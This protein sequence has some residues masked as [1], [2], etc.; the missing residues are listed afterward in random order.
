MRTDSRPTGGR[1]RPS[2]RTETAIV[3]GVGLALTLLAALLA[4]APPNLIR[5]LDHRVYDTLLN[6]T[7]SQA[8]S[9]IPVLI[10]IDDASLQRYGQWPWPRYRLA[11]LIARLDQAGARVIAL[12]LLMPES[13]RTSPEIILQERHRDLGDLSP[14]GVFRNGPPGNDLLLA[15]TL[16]E[17]PVV[18]GYRFDFSSTGKGWAGQEP[19]PLKAMVVHQVAGAASG[20]PKP[21]GVLANLP[22]LAKAAP[23]EGF[24]NAGTDGDGILR[25]VPVLIEGPHGIFP[26][27]AFAALLQATGEEAVKL[28]IRRGAA[29]LHWNGREIPLDGQ[30]NLLLAFRG[31][32]KSYRY[33]SSADVLAGNLPAGTLQGRVA[34][35]GAWASGLGDRHV[36]PTDS[37]FPGM[38]VHAVVIDNLLA[39]VF[40][41]EPPWSR[42][43]QLFF[44]VCLGLLTTFVLSRFDFLADLLLLGTGSLLTAGGAC[45]LFMTQGIYLSP[46]IPVLLLFTSCGLLGLVKY[47]L[48]VRKVYVRTRELATDQDATI[49]GMTLLAASRDKETGAHILRTQ[50]YVEAL[51]RE[52]RHLDKYRTELT[53]ANIELLFKSAP[54]HDIGKVGIPDAILRKPGE[55]SAEEYH[56]MKSHALIGSEALAQT[57]NFLR[58]SGELGYLDYACQ[59]TI[60][61]H[62]KWDGSGYPNGLKG[63]EI[64]LAGR[65]MALADVYDALISERVYKSV[66]SHEQAKE[67]ILAKSD[68]HFDPEVVAAFLRCE[69][70][71]RQI[72]K[73]HADPAALPN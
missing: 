37:A 44:I 73:K 27:L 54:L 23:A 4:V 41:Q 50:R 64:P 65:L 8:P 39:G 60:S 59:V 68:T 62:E 22:M 11:Q 7:V 2:A 71:F 21:S 49:L 31:A 55:L 17:T 14:V 19:A 58:Q 10:G 13:D 36:T 61:H 51:A 38:E 18:L 46:V 12:D 69:D 28:V 29:T 63:E 40:L 52:L 5:F 47:G 32:R 35:V 30:G 56:L 34:I 67:I 3:A 25:R 33:I 6:N 15:T 45:A 9:E 57:A 16:A 1:L 43:A 53:E 20:W 42:G 72:A 70:K 26:S 24:T 66:M 48:E